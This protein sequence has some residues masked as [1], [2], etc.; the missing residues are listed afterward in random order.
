MGVIKVEGLGLVEIE[1]ERP[2]AEEAA[3]IENKYEA[4]QE[5]RRTA[6]GVDKVN[7]SEINLGRLGL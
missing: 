2:N 7:N 6:S 1:G 4:L 3:A 5:E